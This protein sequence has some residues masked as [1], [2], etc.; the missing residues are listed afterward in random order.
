MDS[1]TS[2]AAILGLLP[3]IILFFILVSAFFKVDQQSVAIIERFGKFLRTAQPGLNMRVPLIDQIKGRVSL[4]VLQL[5]VKVETKTKDNVF[6]DIMVSVQ[7][8]ILASKIF[9]AF[10]VLEDPDTQI[11]SFVFDVVRARVPKIDLDDVFEKKD[12][13]AD[14][15]KS[16]LSEVM[17]QFGFEIVK[18]LVTDITP[19]ARVKSAMN[20]INE[21]QRLR[22]AANERGEAEKI[23]KVKQGEAEAEVKI[24]QGK[25]LAGQRRA[26]VDGL[27]DSLDDFQKSIPTSSTQDVMS[28]ILMTQYFDTLKEMSITGK[29]NTIMMPHSPSGLSDLAEQIRSAVFTGTLMSK[30]VEDEIV[31]HSGG[32]PKKSK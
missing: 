31:H 32:T 16:E 28:L 26:I 11:K 3:F 24:L 1:T 9:E 13:I 17:S 2:V 19:D 21:A 8:R 18:A 25:G 5:D 30:T 23:L 6:V 10:Y 12:E 27:R 14:S 20:E 7:Y 29:T 4:R 15:V 22:I